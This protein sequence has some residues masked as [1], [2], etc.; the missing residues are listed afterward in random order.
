MELY[1]YMNNSERVC[2]TLEK[3]LYMMVET[4]FSVNVFVIGIWSIVT[5]E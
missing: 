3:I 4:G 2:L 5:L 1:V